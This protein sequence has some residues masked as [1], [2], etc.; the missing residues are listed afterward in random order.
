MHLHTH[1]QTHTLTYTHTD[2][3]RFTNTRTLSSLREVSRS[4]YLS[5][6]NQCAQGGKTRLVLACAL[7]L[8]SAPGYLQPSPVQD[9]KEAV[10]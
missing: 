7:R 5:K 2:M 1:R 6:H 10:V 9:Q 8:L 4:L 3:H